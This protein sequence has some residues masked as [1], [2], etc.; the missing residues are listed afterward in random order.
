MR[1]FGSKVQEAARALWPDPRPARAG[2]SLYEED[3]ADVLTSR[4]IPLNGVSNFRS[5]LPPFIGDSNTLDLISTTNPG[6]GSGHPAAQPGVGFYGNY[7][8][9]TNRYHDPHTNA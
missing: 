9:F 7:N 8:T 1:A 5:N 2:L 4:G 6:F 3:I